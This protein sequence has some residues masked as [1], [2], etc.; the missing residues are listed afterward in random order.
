MSEIKN[1]R[2]SFDGAEHLK[3]N[4]MMKLGIKGFNNF[5]TI[6]MKFCRII[7]YMYYG[8][9]QLN[10]VVDPTQNGR[11]AAV[12]NSH[13]CICT[14]YFSLAFSRWYFVVEFSRRK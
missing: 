10:F 6:F 14:T 4:H 7:E 13:Y 8:K 12:F 1:G 2:L 9:N 11:M 3:C 5:Q